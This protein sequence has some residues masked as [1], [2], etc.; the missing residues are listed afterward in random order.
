MLS[1]MC[2]FDIQN[3]INLCLLWSH[4]PM[5]TSLTSAIECYWDKIAK[6]DR[7]IGS[8]D[9]SANIDFRCFT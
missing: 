4:K 1:C 5:S 9:L 6:R 3:N 8:F 7:C 2:A